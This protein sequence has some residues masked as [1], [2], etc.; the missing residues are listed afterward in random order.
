MNV[1]LLNGADPRGYSKG[2]YNQA[3]SDVACDFFT[4]RGAAFK[5]TR[6]QD[7]YT[8]EDEVYK[9]DWADV[10][11]Y[12]FP[13]YWFHMPAPMKAYIDDVF[14]AGRGKIWINDGR[15]QG[16]NYGSGGLLNAK[17]MLSTTWNAPDEAFTDP[18]QLFDGK[19][20][21]GALFGFH[22][23]NEFM[24][25]SALPSFSCHNIVKRA[26]LDADKARFLVHL[27]T[28]FDT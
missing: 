6:I 23:M 16:D 19:G 10:I 27:K 4:D 14:M 15:D 22:K 17:Y 9:L 26:D 11:I 5:S 2:A 24:G 18:E 1:F 28:T 21:D 7:G 25:A 20:V 3:L 13:I 12:Q 8:I